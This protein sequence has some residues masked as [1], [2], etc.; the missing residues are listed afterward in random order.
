MKDWVRAAEL[1]NKLKNYRVNGKPLP[2]ISTSTEL[3]TLVRQM[4]DSISRIEYVKVISKRP[5]SPRRLDPK[6]GEMFDP[7]KAAIIYMRSGNEDEAFWLV[8]LFVLC[9]KHLKK[10]YG[11][12]RM[13]YGAFN[14]Q[15]TWTWNEFSKDPSRF[16]FWL[17][18]NIEKI[19]QRRKEFPFGNHRK[20]E[21][22]RGIDTVLSSYAAWIGSSKSHI[23]F[24]NIA[25]A[26][27]GSD[28]KILFDHLYKSMSA[29]YRFGRVGKFDYLTMLG[30]IG[31][32]DIAP[33]SAYLVDATGPVAGAKLLFGGVAGGK[34]TKRDLDRLSIQL[35]ETLGV[36]M[37][38][39]EDA[40]CNW[41]KSPNSYI[42]FRG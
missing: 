31:L 12:L 23:H 9:G 17:H 7:L 8:F 26:A 34:T 19:E 14:D 6:D 33:P 40:L 21:S 25:K 38:V 37:Q 20:Y 4:L 1:E 42:G 27:V 5:L 11:L 15:F 41:Q 10:Q 36:G 22:L 28:P 24:I 3:K 2:G 39:I 30:K 35:D 13:I 29:V 32:V 18:Q 16:S